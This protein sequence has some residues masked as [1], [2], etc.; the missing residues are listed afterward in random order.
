VR[1]DEEAG[2]ISGHSSGPYLEEVGQLLEEVEQ[3]ARS[4]VIVVTARKGDM[5]GPSCFR[6]GSQRVRADLLRV[7]LE[8]AGASLAN[9]DGLC[10]CS[11]ATC[12]P[13]A[14]HCRHPSDDCPEETKGLR[15][16]C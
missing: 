9:V 5:Q 6:H 3:K 12:L 11:T 14:R 16:W 4:V 7:R 15:L 13:A 8:V 2:N 1:V 10:R